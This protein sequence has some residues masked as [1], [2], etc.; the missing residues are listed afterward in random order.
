M[1]DVRVDFQ[2]GGIPK[3][4]SLKTGDKN[5]NLGAL[6]IVIL[7]TGL[8]LFLSVTSDTFFTYRNIYTIFY[9]VSIEFYAV[10]GFTYLLIMGEVDLSIGSV[11]CF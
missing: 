7:T 1:S 6:T 3:N 4:S 2:N 11:Y 9:G 8:F 10:I 5:M